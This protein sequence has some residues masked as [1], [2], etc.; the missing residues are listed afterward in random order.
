[1]LDCEH[2]CIYCKDKK[3]R[4]GYSTVSSHNECFYINECLQCG[5]FF[6]AP[7]P[8]FEQLEQAYDDAYYGLKD[9]KFL[10][11]FEKVINYFRISRALRVRRYITTP[12]RVLDIGCGNGQFLHILQGHGYE[13]YGLERPGKAFERAKKFSDIKITMQELSPATYPDNYFDLITLWHVFEHL[14]NPAQILDIISKSLKPG[15]YLM[16]SL[17]N[18][19]SIQSCLFKGYWLHLDPPRHL[20]FLTPDQLIQEMLKR[21]MILIK[22]NFF[23]L[24]QNPFGIQQSLLNRIFKKRDLLF[25]FLKGNKGY[26]LSYPTLLIIGQLLLFLGSFPIFIILAFLES[27]LGKG[28]TMEMIF[29]KKN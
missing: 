9:Q 29:R 1:M 26:Y 21:G 12:A 19:A 2:A 11:L 4:I 13:A 14:S 25:E 28:G 7:P 27:L 10:P 3:S 24:E 22:K 20:F 5:A 8:T 16:M 23:S 6:L 17:P 15:A 18:I